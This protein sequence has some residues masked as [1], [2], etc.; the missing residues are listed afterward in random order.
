MKRTI[1]AD[2]ADAG[3]VL[4]EDV[5]DRSGRLL[6]SA[7]IPLKD[8][9]LRVLKTWGVA[10]VAIWQE[11]PASATDNSQPSR[12][13]PPPVDEKAYQQAEAVMLNAFRH[14]DLRQSVMHTLFD[15]ATR[16]LASA[17]Q[18]KSQS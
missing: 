5:R 13:P 1:P 4:A 3:S 14:C 18:L 17:I 10:Q 15:L 9:H 6:L 7:G 12:E 2:Q 16:R 8:K 11:A